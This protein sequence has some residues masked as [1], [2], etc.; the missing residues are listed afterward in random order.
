M[1]GSVRAST[2]INFYRSDRSWDVV[3]AARL[4]V[5]VPG[6]Q[7]LHSHLTLLELEEQALVLLVVGSAQKLVVCLGRGA[8]VV[9]L[10]AVLAKY[11][12]VK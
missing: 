6:P 9:V 11:L 8:Q 2:R 7:A 10:E 12:S 5:F 4:L 3:V 1:W